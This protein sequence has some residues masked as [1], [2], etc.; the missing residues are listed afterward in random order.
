MSP[1]QKI[2]SSSVVSAR[3]SFCSLF[4][5]PPIL[6]FLF[7][8]PCCTYSFFVFHS[9]M[10]DCTTRIS[11]PETTRGRIGGPNACVRSPPLV[12]WLKR[13]QWGHMSKQL[14]HR[15]I[16][17]TEENDGGRGRKNRGVA[18][19]G[20]SS[21]TG[22]SSSSYR[23]GQLLQPSFLFVTLRRTSVDGWFCG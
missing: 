3:F 18:S 5:P 14:A 1:N 10:L 12:R 16:E 15:C 23:H 11:L 4:Q 8:S 6:S 2:E 17:F 20:P 21:S 9:S 22:R 13:P 7:S 19:S